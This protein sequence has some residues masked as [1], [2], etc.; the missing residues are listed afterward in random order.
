MADCLDAALEKE[1]LEQCPIKP[2]LVA[3]WV[4][5]QGWGYV[6][7]TYF[8]VESALKAL[9]CV[10]ASKVCRTH[11]LSTLFRALA[12]FDRDRTAR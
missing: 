5:S 1:K 7:A 9:V 10:H 8:L 4:N 12:S 2:D 3:D 6:A 11:S